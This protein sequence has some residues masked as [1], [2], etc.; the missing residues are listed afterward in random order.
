MRICIRIHTYLS[1]SLSLY[2]YIYIY[3]EP[4]TPTRA[5]DN[6]LFKTVIS[7]SLENTSLVNFWGWGR[8]LLFHRWCQRVPR[9]QLGV[10]LGVRG[11]AVATGEA[12]AVVLPVPDVVVLAAFGVLDLH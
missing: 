6:Q 4:P 7:T 8:G 10:A 9:I 11:L 3:T 12:L 5:P 2:I 1:L